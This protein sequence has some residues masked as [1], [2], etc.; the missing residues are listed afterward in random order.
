MKLLLDMNVSPRL[1]PLLVADGINASHWSDHGHAQAL[2]QSIAK[3]A[4]EVGAIIVTHD[5]DFG[6]LLVA[7]GA[8]RP[9]VIQIRADNL[10]VDRLLDLLVVA[11]RDFQAELAAGALITLDLDKTRIRTLPIPQ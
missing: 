5:L 3:L 2:D 4:V 10:S 1:A 6:A 11:C 8:R 7:A 9:S